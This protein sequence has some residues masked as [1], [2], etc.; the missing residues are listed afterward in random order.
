MTQYEYVLKRKQNFPTP[1]VFKEKYRMLNYTEILEIKDY[2]DPDDKDLNDKDPS[3]NY[4]GKEV[5]IL[6]KY[7][8]P[9][10]GNYEKDFMYRG[11]LIASQKANM[12]YETH[13]WFTNYIKKEPVFLSK[14]RF[15]DQLEFYISNNL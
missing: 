9:L 15:I 13:I 5:I 8:K 3:N 7:P 14:K 2:K 12:S 10:F 11:H 1:S 4:I 6:Y